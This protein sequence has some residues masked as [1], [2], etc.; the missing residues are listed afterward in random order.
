MPEVQLSLS[1]SCFPQTSVRSFEN[2][3]TCIVFEN[4][5]FNGITETGIRKHV[6]KGE[7]QTGDSMVL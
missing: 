2:K 3:R 6:E 7:V 5:S 4:E 1:G